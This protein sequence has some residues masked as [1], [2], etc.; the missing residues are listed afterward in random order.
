MPYLYVIHKHRVPRHWNVL[1][2]CCTFYSPSCEESN[3][4]S[5]I[6]ALWVAHVGSVEEK[7]GVVGLEKYRPG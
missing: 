5:V 3:E 6:C 2:C 7:F 4:W 1:I